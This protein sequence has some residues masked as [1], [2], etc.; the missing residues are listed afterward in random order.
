MIVRLTNRAIRYG[1][2]SYAYASGGSSPY[3]YSVL[4]GGA[5]GT[6]GS[7]TGLYTAPV[8]SERTEDTIRAVDATTSSSATVSV[9]V[10]D[11]LILFCDI[12]ETELGLANGRVYLW[13]QKI[14]QPKDSSLY[15]AV[16]EI[17]CKPFGNTNRLNSAGEAEQSINMQSTLQL[18]I[19]SRGPSARTR[20]EEVILALNSNYAQSQQER[21]G[22]YIGKISPGTQFV[23]LSEV[24]GAAIPNRYSITVQMQYAVRKNKVVPYID[25]F[26]DPTVITDP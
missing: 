6:I 3:V 17:S 11:P 20:K 22:F 7:L 8:T 4:P 2:V 12:I 5:G 16:S 15:V 13:N 10:G 18:D 21:N 23:N 14:M 26:S 25:T 19:I 24:D 9:L 1:M